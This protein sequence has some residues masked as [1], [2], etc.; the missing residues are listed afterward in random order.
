MNRASPSGPRPAT[1]AA[2]TTKTTMTPATA[3]KPAPK[4]AA[5]VAPSPLPAPAPKP[6]MATAPAALAAA[7]LL[8]FAG[9]GADTGRAA[10]E[11]GV[12]AYRGGNYP[13]AERLLTRAAQRITG[14]ADLYYY[15]GAARLKLGSPD[16][17]YDAFNIAL[18]SDASHGEALAGMGEAAFFKNELPKARG[19]FEQALRS[20]LATGAARAMALNG[21]SMVRREEKKPA[22]ARLCLLRALRADR[23]YAPTYY[24]LALLYSEAYGLREEALDQLGLFLRLEEGD[25]P[26][27][28]K[29]QNHF[30][31]IAEALRRQNAAAA[32]G[33]AP[34]RD[35]AAARERL[36]E[37][38]ALFAAKRYPRAAKAYRDALAADPLCFEA[39]MGRGAAA[40]RQGLRADALDAYRLAAKLKPGALAAHI[41][42]AEQA[43]QMHRCEE[44]ER[45][46]APAIAR[47][48]FHEPAADLMARIR[49]AQKSAAEA[50]RDTEKARE[51]AAE[52]REYGAFY[53][54][55]L[56]EGDPRKDDYR[57]W[58]DEAAA[59]R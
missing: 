55:L 15:L 8:L 27:R 28:E 19:L 54:S 25:S 53:L 18:D 59:A 23:S 12:A 31:R 24:N 6:A 13:E 45:L 47:S 33:P 29:A 39:A 14:S 46:L 40:A 32:A 48:P 20:R 44:A 3:P 50:R 56:R 10:F 34:R 21:L 7:A 58:L 16:A 42:A 38:A 49:F 9:C 5:A 11:K 1:A 52:L 26:Y 41:G 51:Y 37:A 22:L 57:K 30:R 2:P 17:A 4:P 36:Q 35:A 43:F